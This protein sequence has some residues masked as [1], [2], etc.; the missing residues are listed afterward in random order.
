MCDDKKK[1]I[2]DV[3]DDMV[4]DF[5]YYNRK[6]DEVLPDGSI[7]QAVKDGIVTIDEM[8]NYFRR[9]LTDVLA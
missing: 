7:E 6:E 9:C 8:C 3:I 5:V 4:S 2:M 1:Y